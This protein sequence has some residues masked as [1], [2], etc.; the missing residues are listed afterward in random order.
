MILP[1]EPVDVAEPEILPENSTLP[2]LALTKLEAKSPATKAPLA[3]M[4]PSTVNS[5]VGLD[6]PMPTMP[7]LKN[8]LPLELR[9]TLSV[10]SASYSVRLDELP[11][12]PT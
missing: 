3:L 12:A 6:V 4:L 8:Q 11:L 7:P 10:S 1:N 5:I 2:V 9:R